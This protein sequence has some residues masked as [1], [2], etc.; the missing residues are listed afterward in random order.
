VLG[1][2]PLMQTILELIAAVSDAAEHTPDA[3]ITLTH[4][5]D[6]SKWMQ[7]LHD[8]INLSYP[9]AANP[10]KQFADLALPHA[11]EVRVGFW[12]PKLF[13]DFECSTLS[14]VQVAEILTAYMSA[15]FG[16]SDVSEY[17]VSF[18]LA[19]RGKIEADNTRDFLREI[20]KLKRRLEGRTSATPKPTTNSDRTEP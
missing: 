15:V 9:F 16:T 8:K 7:L 2:K 1:V 5:S 10:A 13:A 17:K 18:D 4:H 14:D 6:D 3:M 20:V 19:E 12:E 11:A